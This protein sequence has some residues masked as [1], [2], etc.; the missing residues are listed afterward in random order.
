MLTTPQ[1]VTRPTT[2]F[3]IPSIYDCTFEDDFC[4]WTF[5]TDRALNRTRNQGA[6]STAETGPQFDVTTHT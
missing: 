3:Q 5:L 6:T 1:T 2:P 4:Q